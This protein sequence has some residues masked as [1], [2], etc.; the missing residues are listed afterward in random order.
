MEIKNIITVLSFVFISTISQATLMDFEDFTDSNTTEGTLNSFS[1][2][3]LSVLITAGN[4]QGGFNYDPYLD[5]GN[6]GIGVCKNSLV[7]AYPD[8]GTNN[9]CRT[10]DGSASAA[11]DD[12]L[13]F[14]EYLRLDFSELVTINDIFFRDSHHHNLNGI[15]QFAVDGGVFNSYLFTNGLRP[16]LNLTGTTFDI[17]IGANDNELYLSRLNVQPIPEPTT[18]VLLGLGIMGVI[19][20]RK[21]AA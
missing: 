12:N 2:G 14:M 11:G 21:R 20:A 3:S 7:S 19:S 13:Q 9:K 16:V 15:V 10:P 17:T 6:A 4:T 18:L 5:Y 1:S 8:S